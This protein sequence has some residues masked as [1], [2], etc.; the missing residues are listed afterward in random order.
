MFVWVIFILLVVLPLV[1]CL[2]LASEGRTNTAWAVTAAAAVVSFVCWLGALGTKGWD[3]LGWLLFAF[4]AS[5]V[6]AG[7]LLGTVV[8]IVMARRRR[9]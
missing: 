1:L 9:R 6:L 8:G 4:G 3:A 5:A 2:P 7:A